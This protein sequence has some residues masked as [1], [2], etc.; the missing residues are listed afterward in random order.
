MGAAK[1]A[2]VP[3]LRLHFGRPSQSNIDREVAP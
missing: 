2:A 3:C 1:T